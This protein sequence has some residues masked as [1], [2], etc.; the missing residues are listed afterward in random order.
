MIPSFAQPDRARRCR[1][2]AAGTCS[3][4]LGDFN[5]LSTEQMQ[6]VEDDSVRAH[7]LRGRAAAGAVRPLGRHDALQLV[8]LGH[9]RAGAARRLADPARRRSPQP[10]PRGATDLHHAGAARPGD[11]VR[12]H[13]AAASFEPHLRRV[14]ETLRERRDAMLAALAEH[15]PEATCVAARGRVLRLARSSRRACGRPRRRSRAPRASPPFAGTEFGSTSSYLR[16]SYAAVGAAEIPE[17][18]V[19]LGRAARDELER[20]RLTH[21]A[22]WR[23]R[24]PLPL[25]FRARPCGRPRRALRSSFALLAL[26]LGAAG[27]LVRRDGSAK[28]TEEE[29][30][31]CE[32]EKPRRGGVCRHHGVSAS[33]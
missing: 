4:S 29:K 6:L 23:F 12:V 20:G 26:V 7:A 16:L 18:I 21:R 30:S 2:G 13:H 19:R 33:R 25:T 28:G 27:N 8:V 15:L 11:G 17:G 5:R 14:R 22:R 9:D 10:S 31:C 1:S 3:S 32:R 24:P